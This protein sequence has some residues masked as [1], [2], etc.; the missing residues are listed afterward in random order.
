MKMADL[1]VLNEDE[2]RAKIKDLKQEQLHL[3]IQQQSGQLEK[4]S[5]IQEIRKT[6]ARIETLLSAKRLEKT[7]KA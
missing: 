1:R 6:I 2:L 5:R 3:R 7:A 4:P